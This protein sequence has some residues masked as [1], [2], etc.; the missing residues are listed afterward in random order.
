MNYNVEYSLDGNTVTQLSTFISRTQ[1]LTIRLKADNPKIRNIK[2]VFN[3]K[4]FY[5]VRD[6][7]NTYSIQLYKNM[8]NE[9]VN[10]MSFVKEYNNNKKDEVTNSLNVTLYKANIIQAD[11]NYIDFL[12]AILNKTLRKFEK[13]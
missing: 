8:V 3:N 10:T 13:E 5:M 12:F 11:F 6:E 2:I 9:G 1:K 4:E 7:K